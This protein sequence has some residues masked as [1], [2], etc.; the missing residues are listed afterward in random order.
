MPR[1]L[2]YFYSPEMC[3]GQGELSVCSNLCQI[4][5]WNWSFNRYEAEKF[6]N[7]L[8]GGFKGVNMTFPKLAGGVNKKGEAGA[9]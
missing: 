9:I 7:I 3:R 1:P 2:K 6:Q 4:S 5:S 8:T